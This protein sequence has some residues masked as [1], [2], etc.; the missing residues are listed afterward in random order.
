MSELRKRV[1]VSLVFIPVLIAAL[2]LG[3][4]PLVLI[5]FLVSTLGTVEYFQIMQSSGIRLPCF[6]LALVPAVC[7]ALVYVRT[8]DLPVIWIAFLILALAKIVSWKEGTGLYDMFAGI[9]GL[10]YVGVVPAMIIRIGHDNSGSQILLAMVLMI[11]I[12]D[13]VAYFIGMRFGK[14]RKVTLIS[15]RKSIEGFMAG[16]LAPALIVLILYVTG[17]KLLS[18]RSMIL[19]AVSAGVIGQLGDLVESMVK[20][21]AGVKD[22]S[23]LI[24]GHGG[25]L[26]RT[27]S[28]LLAG[29]FLYVTMQVLS[30]IGY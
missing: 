22:S 16:L 7:L 26:D 17:F 8:L 24:P 14:H 6:F 15:P 27:D 23:H 1:L 9:W 3:G 29:S 13:S 12:V 20:R 10:V 5:F 28:I 4:L 2:Y 18:L 30:F 11:W 19:V 25:I 21:F